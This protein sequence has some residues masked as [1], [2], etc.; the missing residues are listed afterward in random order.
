LGND[1]TY[2][3]HIIKFGTKAL[4]EQVTQQHT[5]PMYQWCDWCCQ[6]SGWFHYY[7]Q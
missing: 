1:V 5:L 6:R 7:C 2:N 3:L 4:D